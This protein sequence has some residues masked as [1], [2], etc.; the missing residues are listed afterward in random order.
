MGRRR[1]YYIGRRDEQRWRRVID[2]RK[3][4]PP[5]PRDQRD[6]RVEIVHLP[7]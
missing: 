7:L 6:Q 4:D 3:L 1:K 2:I 5:R